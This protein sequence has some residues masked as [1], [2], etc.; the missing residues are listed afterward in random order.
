[1]ASPAGEPYT[2]GSSGRGE[3]RRGRFGRQA[4][5]ARAL[6]ICESRVTAAPSVLHGVD[7]RAFVIAWRSL[8]AL[9]GLAGF[10]R[11][12]DGLQ[13]GGLIVAGGGPGGVQAVRF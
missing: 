11:R 8:R 2:A 7:Q 3:E 1:M 10:E 4:A 9:G 6:C 13:L 5:K 12:R